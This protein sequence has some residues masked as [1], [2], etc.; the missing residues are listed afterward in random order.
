ME[1]TIKYNDLFSEE[2]AQAYSV[3]EEKLEDLYMQWLNGQELSEQ[4]Q[5]LVSLY[6][7]EIEPEDFIEI[8]EESEPIDV[9]ELEVFMRVLNKLKKVGI[10]GLETVLSQ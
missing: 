10:T 7:Q 2:V 3:F 8:I 9:R 4:E 6:Q 1:I 5:Q